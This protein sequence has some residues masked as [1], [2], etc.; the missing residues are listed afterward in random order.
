MERDVR[1]LYVTVRICRHKGADFSGRESGI[2]TDGKRIMRKKQAF[3]LG[4][5]QPQAV[6]ISDIAI[7]MRFFSFIATM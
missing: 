5:I 4:K 6:S 3:T 2:Y 1:V 7:L